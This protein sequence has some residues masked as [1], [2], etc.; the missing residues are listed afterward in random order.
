MPRDIEEFRDASAGIRHFWYLGA[1][2]IDSQTSQL[3]G[4][5]EQ[6]SRESVKRGRGTAGR[7]A[8]QI[9]GFLHL[10]SL[11]GDAELTSSYERI[12]ELTTTLSHP[13]KVDLLIKHH[14]SENALLEVDLDAPSTADDDDSPAAWAGYALLSGAF[15]YKS[16]TDGY[17]LLESA[18]QWAHGDGP[19]L[20]V[21]LD[22][23]QFTQRHHVF[24]D[25]K[26][27]L[28]RHTIFCQCVP[29][30]NAVWAEPFAIWLDH[31]A[32][33]T[34]ADTPT[35]RQG[36]PVGRSAPR[37]RMVT[38]RPAR[39]PDAPSIPAYPIIR[40][41]LDPDFLA[42]QI[43]EVQRAVARGAH[44]SRL[45][46]G[47]YEE[48][49]H[50]LEAFSPDRILMPRNP[51]DSLAQSALTFAIE[52]RAD[53]LLEPA[54]PEW[55]DVAHAV[56]RSNDV[57]RGEGPCDPRW[58][59]A[60]IAD[61]LA[62][63]EQLEHRTPPP[64]RPSSPNQ[65]APDARVVLVSDWATGLPCALAVAQRIRD[66]VAEAKDE[67]RDVHVIHLGD[68]YYSGWRE[69]YA[70][71]FLAHWPVD[72]GE[73]GVH[74]WALPG[75]HDLY[76]GGHGYFGFLLADPRFRLQ[77]GSSWFSLE[78]ESWQILGLDSSYLDED[79]HDPEVEWVK[80][81][82]RGERRTILLAH[83]PMESMYECAAFG[84]PSTLGPVLQDLGPVDAFFWGHEHRSIIYSPYPYDY[85]T[86]YANLS[87][88]IGNGGVPRM[89][90]EPERPPAG[91]ERSYE[92]VTWV[93]AGP[94]YRPLNGF[95]IID[96][97][98]SA[99]IVTY[100]D[101]RGTELYT[102]PL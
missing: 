76:S 16:R 90:S 68:A 6:E 63:L 70:A 102:Q 97:D 23:E 26:A 27:G 83:H 100:V 51:F 2:N 95:V 65:L 43:R 56:M 93:R 79:L 34:P 57:L 72:P 38:R 36:K 74:S 28:F 1:T 42:T 14:R 66:A 10:G 99:A 80:S 24:M 87:S 81:R 5:L 86:P 92:P 73:E 9:G 8:I 22:T 89:L 54:P 30:D 52:S 35:G 12:V 29:R 19:F 62:A 58:I 55:A 13:N 3:R 48:F 37:R 69:E 47:H 32:A 15:R 31:S 91:N 60:C 33:T 49:I 46:P 61:G 21:A 41:I 18:A 75:N 71:R 84:L 39:D 82:I 96:F 7:L 17:A 67:G 85:D 11:R 88:C 94:Y 20:C 44:R 50:R 40:E 98:E 53:D 59:E 4:R 78:S 101:E 77:R 45:R 64:P 25:A